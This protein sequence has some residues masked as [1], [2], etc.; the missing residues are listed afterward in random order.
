MAYH[1]HVGKAVDKVIS[2][3]QTVAYHKHVGKA[4]EKKISKSHPF[5]PSLLFL[6][7][8]NLPPHHMP[9]DLLAIAVINPGKFGVDPCSA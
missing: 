5:F 3:G 6:T 2:K 4:A 1:K 7:L 8:S 9:C